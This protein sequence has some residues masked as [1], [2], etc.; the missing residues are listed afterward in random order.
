MLLL[1][2]LNLNSDFAGNPSSALE[3]KLQ[4]HLVQ[5]VPWGSMASCVPGNYRSHSGTL[6]GAATSLLSESNAFLIVSRSNSLI[7]SWSFIFFVMREGTS[8]DRD[9]SCCDR[10][11][12]PI[13]SLEPGASVPLQR[14]HLNFSTIPVPSSPTKQFH[15]P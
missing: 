2:H 9:D 5:K 15:D 14:L 11:E 10:A 12:E 6:P 8:S 7:V 1:H 13:K 3:G 4:N